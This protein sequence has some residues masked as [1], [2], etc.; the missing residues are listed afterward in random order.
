M[1]GNYRQDSQ[2][3]VLTSIIGALNL[4]SPN[5]LQSIPL[6]QL[7]HQC[8]TPQEVLKLSI[9]FE[10]SPKYLGVILDRTLSYKEH[11]TKVSAKVQGITSSN[12]QLKQTGTFLYLSSPPHLISRTHSSKWP[13]RKCIRSIHQL[14]VWDHTG[15]A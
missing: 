9:P 5:S 15:Q 7:S 13:G 10:K 6:G 14:S 1:H 8:Q 12:T 4:T 11:L 2:L 3:S